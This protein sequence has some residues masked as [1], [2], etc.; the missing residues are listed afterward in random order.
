[1]GSTLTLAN[2]RTQVRNHIDEPTANYWSEVELNSAIQS[3]ERDLWRKVLALRKDYWLS[4]TGFVLT[5]VAG[6]YA[7][8]V[9]SGGLPTDLWRI[10]S[11]R[12][13]QAGFQG[14]QWIPGNP[15]SAEFIEGLRSD[16]PIY[17]PFR[18]FY[19][20]RNQQT[21]WVSPLPQ[22]SITAQVDYIQQPVVQTADTDTFLI[23]DAFLNFVEY[24]AAADALSKG[25][26]GD[27]AYWTQ[28]ASNA[29]AEIRDGLDTPRSDQG[30]DVVQGCFS[31]GG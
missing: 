21:L 25:P 6:Q 10:E 13:T 16:T 12:T 1:M 27:S 9:A 11:I 14:L 23:P 17:N 5:L 7:Y 4:P 26:V 3:A 29:W 18:Q 24:L 15:T 28:R 19:A 31:D 22:Q 8:T 30:P 2:V 20:L